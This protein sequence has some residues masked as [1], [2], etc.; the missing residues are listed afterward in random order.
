MARRRKHDGV[1]YRRRESAVW[2][3]RYSDRGGRR[4]REST[5]TEDWHEAQKKL[6]ERLQA[7]DGN[8]LEIVRKGEGLP[9]GQWVEIFLKNN[10][11]P[12]VRTEKT[13]V[14]N[15]RAANHLN[16]Y[17][18]TRML[19]DLTA[20]QI[21]FYLRE[22]LRQRI[23]IKIRNGY[24]E[25][26]LVKATTV[27]QEFRVLRRMLNVAV[28]KKLLP[29][30]P[31]SGVEFPVS[32]KGLF[33]PHYMAWSEQQL[34]E[35]HAPDYLRNIIRILTETGLRVY[36]EL[37]PLKKE[38]LDLMNAKILVSDSKTPNGVAELALTE[39]AVEAIQSQIHL[40]GPSE[41]L[42]PSDLNP[43]GHQK[44]LRSVWRLTLKR[45]GVRYF[46]IYDLRS[47]YATRLSA[48][49]V[50]DEWVT[51]LLRQGDAQVFKKY[52]QMK[53][54]MQREALSKINRRA[55]EMPLLG[56]VAVSEFANSGTVLA[57]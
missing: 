46:R 55:N 44:S 10:S 37:L 39:L 41:F 43:T 23:R 28:R 24:R 51:Q 29:L 57:Q 35:R 30:N 16:R 3:I 18:A 40:A 6:R 22:R 8:I 11:K 15:I 4:V 47:T 36:K 50:A 2:W 56:A 19:A 9:F 13:H 5:F 25:G 32:L 49:G 26:R 21:E 48:G 17:F 7:R 54:Q 52:S 53:L 45:A 12:P 20:D 1:V 33:R 42:F 34:I 31:C 14:A 38:H 27:H